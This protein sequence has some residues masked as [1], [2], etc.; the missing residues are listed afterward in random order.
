LE[1]VRRR[2]L[3]LVSYDTECVLDICSREAL[4]GSDREIGRREC[5]HRQFDILQRSIDPQQAALAS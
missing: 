4:E 5:D 3:S 1:V 2:G